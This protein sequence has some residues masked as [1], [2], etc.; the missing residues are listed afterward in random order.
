MKKFPHLSVSLLICFIL[1]TSTTYAQKNFTVQ[2]N[3]LDE[4][5]TSQEGLHFNN[6]NFNLS[7][8]SFIGFTTEFRCS[9][10]NKSETKKAFALFVVGFDETDQILV[11]Y[12]LRL[13][14]FSIKPGEIKEV[15]ESA[16]SKGTE[17]V[18]YFKIRIIVRETKI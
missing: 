13:M 14:F 5:T 11:A 10:K 7:D 15:D 9:V 1:Y 6:F 4:F 8:N 18:K 3:N 2:L 16:I 12:S 17:N